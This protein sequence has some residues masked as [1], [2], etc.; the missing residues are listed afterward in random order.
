MAGTH[1]DCN[2][3]M[4]MCVGPAYMCSSGMRVPSQSFST[5]Y[6]I[7]QPCSTSQPRALALTHHLRLCKR[8]QLATGSSA[9]FGLK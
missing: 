2:S 4:F 5:K 3:S 8:P 6:V 9:F 1:V 7:R